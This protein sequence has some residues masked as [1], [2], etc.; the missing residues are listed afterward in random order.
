M[1]QSFDTAGRAYGKP[2]AHPDEAIVRCGPGTLGGELLRR[3]WQPVALAKDVADLPQS[4]KILDEELIL[5]RDRSGTYGLLYPRC[6]HRGASLLYG[7]I[8]QRGIRCCYHG[9]LY[10]EQGRCLEMPCEPD[11]P[12]KNHIRQPWYPLVEKFG[13]L[14]AYMGPPDRQPLFPRFSLEDDLEPGEEIASYTRDTGPNGGGRQGVPE[15]LAAWSD[16][17]WW[18]MFDNF[19]DAFHVVVLHNAIN[20]TQFEESLAIIP[21]VEFQYTADGVRSIQHRKLADGRLHQRVSQVILPNMNG[22]AGVTDDDLGPSGL[23]WTVPIDDTHF[24]NFGISRYNRNAPTRGD[25]S[26]LGM[27]QPD[28]GP[29]HGK[30]FREWSLEDHQRWQTDYMAQ[31]AQGDISLHSEEHLTRIDRGTAMMRRL[32]GQQAEAVAQGKDPIGVGFDQPYYIKLYA[33][34]AILD[35]TTLKCID[36]FDGR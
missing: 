33:G 24:R 28:W 34:N 32:F 29:S 26:Q 5:Y 18:Q 15:R 20:G 12:A 4:I 19:M 17:N 7:K 13:I 35:Q 8:E 21:E 3:Y 16:Y 2:S 11:N 14:F 25:Y 22:T 36:G 9:W 27:F 6:M 1:T 23:G 31:K 30:P 10:D